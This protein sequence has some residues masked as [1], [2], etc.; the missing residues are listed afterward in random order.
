MTNGLARDSTTMGRRVCAAL[1]LSHPLGQRSTRVR[2]VAC[3][4]SRLRSRTLRVTAAGALGRSSMFRV[5]MRLVL[6]PTG[7]GEPNPLDNGEIQSYSSTFFF[8]EL[9]RE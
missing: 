1:A 8:G 4:R 2:S 6:Y 7:P 9:G 3:S 5:P